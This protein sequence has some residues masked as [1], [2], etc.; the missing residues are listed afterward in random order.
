MLSLDN[1]KGGAITPAL[2]LT[3]EKTAKTLE[4]ELLD[5]NINMVQIFLLTS[6]CSRDGLRKKSRMQIF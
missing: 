1:L 5:R 2:L 6:R 4:E 3:V